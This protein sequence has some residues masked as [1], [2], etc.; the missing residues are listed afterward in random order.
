MSFCDDSLTEHDLV[1]HFEYMTS[2][3]KADRPAYVPVCATSSN[4]IPLK[5]IHYTA[6]Q[7]AL[8]KGQL[9][10]LDAGCEW[11]G[12][13]SDIT[14]TFPVDGKFSSPQRDLYLCLLDVQNELLK[15]ITEEQGY[16]LLGIHSKSAT[17][18]T[19]GLRNL[20]FK[21]ISAAEV[22][23]RIYPHFVSHPVGIDLHDTPVIER[24][25]KCVKVSYT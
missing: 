7:S 11:G 23:R 15:L 5:P 20:G 16:H 22:E 3:L 6:N 19:Q 13:A 21:D 14:R 9:V 18:L 8:Q 10:L 12:Y 4:D 17:L 2:L 25:E 24:N 1:A